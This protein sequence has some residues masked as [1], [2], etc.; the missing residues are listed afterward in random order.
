M[1]KIK[2]GFS[3]R[4]KF[5][6]I[7]QS[8]MVLERTPF[9]HVYVRISSESLSRDLIY[10]ASGTAVHFKAVK[11]FDRDNI[12]VEEYEVDL[13]DDTYIKVMQFC[14][15]NA[16]MPYGLMSLLGFVPVYLGRSLG[17]TWRNPWR[18]G[19]RTY[20]CS[21][22]GAV[23]LNLAGGGLLLGETEITPKALYEFIRNRY[24]RVT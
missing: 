13:D 7:S 8:I 19:D 20:V 10:E 23:I 18:D 1:K 14:V 9:S 17:R 16:G 4:R 24:R 5:N 22:L 15:D 12:V 6:F 2:I 11:L 3:K 21:E